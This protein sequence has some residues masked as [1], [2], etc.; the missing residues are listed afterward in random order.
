MKRFA[1]MTAA[2]AM[3]LAFAS[4]AR[5]ADVGVAPDYAAPPPVATGPSWTGLYL[6]LHGGGGWSHVSASTAPSGVIVGALGDPGLQSTGLSGAVFGGQLGYNWQVANWVFGAEGDFS[7]AG[8]NG[9]TQSVFPSIAPGG[10]QDSIQV[11]QNIGWLASARGRLGYVWGTL[12]L[13][14]TGGAAWA[15]VDSKVLVNDGATGTSAAGSFTDHRS[16][17]TLGAGYEWMIA[18]NWIGRAEYLYYSFGNNTLNRTVTFPGGLGT[19]TIT[20]NKLNTNVVRVGLSYK[21]DWPR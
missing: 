17:W 9:A 19:D 15:N 4:T 12:L 13:Y 21:F 8:L 10:F 5:A 1:L 11:H 18:P 6:G 3:S 7:S 14:V 2:A 16:G 20:T